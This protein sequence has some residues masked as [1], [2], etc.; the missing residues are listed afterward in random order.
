MAEAQKV[1]QKQAQKAPQKKGRTGGIT[2][3]VWW[4]FAAVGLYYLL[5]DRRE[6]WW[7]YLPYLLLMACPVL[8]IFRRYG[9]HRRSDL[10]QPGAMTPAG[11]KR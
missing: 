9:G 1:P 3:V 6:N 7:D 4:A 10:L 2:G 5:F 11:K 8:D